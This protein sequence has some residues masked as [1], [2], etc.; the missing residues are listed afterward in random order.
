M[1]CPPEF[2]R[3]FKERFAAKH[4]A[5]K[6]T[7]LRQGEISE[8][9]YLVESGALRLWY[10]DDG[11]DVT[12][13]FFLAGDIV[14]SLESFYQNV[15]SQFGLEA[16]L[17][18]TVRAG[19]RHDFESM[20]ENS[21]AFSRQMLAVAVQCMAD[22]QMLFLNRITRNPEDRYRMLVSTEPHL[23]DVVP[24]H[25]I[26]SYLGITPVS[27]SRIRKKLAAVNA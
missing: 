10:N 5:K 25:Y 19:A 22:Y 27:L 16:I 7:L 2:Q 13:K 24:H 17:P 8:F 20:L 15:P 9:A 14:S 18:T 26:A 4:L 6:H 23:F 11:N 12:V 1:N 21:P 3:L